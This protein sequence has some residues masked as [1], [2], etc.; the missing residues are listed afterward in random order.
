MTAAPPRHE[1]RAAL[2]LPPTAPRAAVDARL[3]DV[4]R[5]NAFMGPYARGD[6]QISPNQAAFLIDPHREVLFGG[7]TKGG[8]ALALSTPLPTPTGWTTMEAVRI[9]DWLLD[10]QGRPCR[11]VAHSLIMFGHDVFDVVFD[12]GS[13]I[14]ADGDHRWLTSTVASRQV[15]SRRKHRPA[16]QFPQLSRPQQA[17]HPQ[18]RTTRD[19]AETLIVRGRPNHTVALCAPLVLPDLP[20]PVDPYVLGV[21]LGDGTTASGAFTSADIEIVDMVSAAGYAAHRRSASNGPYDYGTYGLA[22]QLRQA[23]V[24]GNKHIPPVYL[25]A[26]VDQRRALLQGL[27]DT[28]GT[29][30]ARGQ[31][32]FDTTSVALAQGVVELLHSLGVRTRLRLSTARLYGRDCGLR[33][34][35]KFVADWPIFRLPRKA[36]R[37]RDAV[38][39]RHRTI[40]EVRPVPTEPVKCV[41]VD[42][43]SHLY[44]AGDAMIPTHNT[45]AF[46]IDALRF[47]DIGHYQ[48]LILDRA[49]TNLTRGDG[50]IPRFR[51]WTSDPRLGVKWDDENHAG[52]FP[53]GAKITFGFI[54]RPEDAGRYKRAN[55]LRIYWEE[56][57]EH[58]PD[59]LPTAPPSYYLYLFT[60]LARPAGSPIPLAVRANSN[61]DGPGRLWVKTRWGIGHD[62]DGA[63]L[64]PPPPS[65][66]YIPANYRTNPGVDHVQIE[67]AFAETSEVT[68]AQLLDSD[69]DITATGDFFDVDAIRLVPGLPAAGV[70]VRYRGWDKAGTDASDPNAKRAK[71]TVGLRVSRVDRRI[72]GV[73][74]VI[75]DCIRQQWGIDKR[76]RA[77]AE[78]AGLYDPTIPPSAREVATPD[79]F[80]TPGQVDTWIII[81]QEPADA[82]KQSAQISVSQLNGRVVKVFKPSTDKETRAR[83][84]A[85]Q[86][87]AGN[88]GM[89]PGPW[90]AA[91]KA[92][93]KAFSK[94]A[95]YKDIVDTLSMIHNEIALLQPP[96]L[97]ASSPGQRR[98]LVVPAGLPAGLR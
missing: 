40:V 5:F 45:D 24:L 64:P 34:R 35:L 41:A 79:P 19:I 17:S 30:D 26:S 63:P 29:V 33:Y 31:C 61:P 70:L 58:P 13:I 83:A 85:S 6:K 57:T 27:M 62:D 86:I 42:S 43:P 7:A 15:D 1:L 93:L 73:E 77:I 16:P 59:E 78:T 22:P 38:K 80:Q 25:R 32:E 44:L 91:V 97:P 95:K 10:D 50:I 72:Y 39:C 81:E 74:F 76:D 54:E 87:N 48:A 84:C 51:E 65:R 52:I 94:R 66:H 71:Y 47:V 75:E 46:L 90:N 9:G 60:R 21:W 88:Y 98:A 53:S 14:R 89:V 37:Q 3:V 20:L 67:A 92:E 69:W 28:D 56:L 23:G 12:D 2:G 49:F 82:G 11:V 55:Y 36:T 8:K 4:L 18:I 96:A 68:R